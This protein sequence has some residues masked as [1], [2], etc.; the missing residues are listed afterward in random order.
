MELSE[1]RVNRV[2]D[3]LGSYWAINR[4]TAKHAEQNALSLGLSLQ[5]MAILNILYGRPGSTVDDL[6]KKLFTSTE[7]ISANVDGLVHARLVE[8]MNTEFVENAD[9]WRLQLTEKGKEMSE[10]STQNAFAYKAML[11]ALDEIDDE[12]IDTLIRINR[13][14]EGLLK[15]D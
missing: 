4:I 3:V 2:R 11:K 13:K 8:K 6:K 10:R 1:D 9:A 5:Q 15:A 7:V 14:I 12:D